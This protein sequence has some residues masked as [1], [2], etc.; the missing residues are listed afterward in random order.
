MSIVNKKLRVGDREFYFLA[1]LM[2]LLDLFLQLRLKALGYGVLNL[3]FSFGLGSSGGVILIWV[4]GALL[5]L[6]WRNFLKV[7]SKAWFLVLVGGSVN[8][9]MRVSG[10]GV[11]D[12][13]S[14]PLMPFRNNLSDIMISLGVILL[15]WQEL[16]QSA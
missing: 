14:I 6:G 16:K 15:V 10:G 3:G 8:F 9:V 4:I 1:I 12:Y 2:G 13:L 5:I 11:W 7:K